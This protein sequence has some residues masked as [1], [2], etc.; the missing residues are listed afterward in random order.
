[1][2]DAAQPSQP[3]SFGPYTPVRQVGDTYYIS[4]QVG[5]DPKTMLASS[6]VAAQVGQAL[7]NLGTVLRSVGLTH[8]DVVKTTL[9][10]TDMGQFSRINE[11]YIAYFHEPRPARTTVGVAELPRLGGDTKLL[12][13]IEAVAV[14][15]TS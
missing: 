9:Y 13:E 2:T 3:V 11:V 14:R 6:E 15:S 1:M 4:G 8:D 10:V 5:I 12:F 7:K